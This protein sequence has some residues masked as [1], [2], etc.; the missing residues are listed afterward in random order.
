MTAKEFQD[1][2][3]RV[4]YSGIA[5]DAGIGRGYWSYKASTDTELKPK[6]VLAL[7]AALRSKAHELLAYAN[8]CEKEAVGEKAR[9]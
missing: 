5:K 1:R 4:T 9:K 7:V 3:P 6:E 2:C 8:E